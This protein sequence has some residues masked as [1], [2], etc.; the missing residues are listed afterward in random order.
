MSGTL[1]AG[2]ATSNIT[3]WLDV[4]IPGNFKPSY[5]ADVQDELLAKALVLDNGH[6]R[7]AVVTCDLIVIPQTIADEAK[8]RIQERCNIPP[9]CVMINATH[10]HSGAAI[11]DLLSTP[12]NAD[13]IAWV[14]LKIADAVERALRQLRPARIGFAS[15]TE[16]RISFYRRWRMNDGTV[17]M[18][19][20][21]NN[22]D[23]VEPMG[24]IDP[25][26]AMLY[27]EDECDNPIAVAASFSLHYVGVDHGKQVSPDYFGHF[28]R[29]MRRYLGNTCVP[30]L[31]NAASGQ[32]NNIDFSGQRIWKDRGHKQAKKMA[33]VLAGHI[34]TEIQLMDMQDTLELHSKIDTFTYNRKTITDEDLKIAGRILNGDCEYTTGPFSWVVGQPIPKERAPTYAVECQRLAKL[35]EALA[36]PVQAIRLNDAAI[37]GLPG[38]IFVETGLDI[39]AKSSASPLLLVSL[40]NSYIGY[41]CTDTMLTQEGGYETWA[42]LSS[43]GGI[44]TGPAMTSLSLDLLKKLGF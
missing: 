15:A 14:P 29:I 28:Y 21:R 43:L 37:L 26:L 23:L 30:I 38:E 27:V 35:P 34:I 36:A 9:E 10:T 20:G 16:D 44:G 11:A 12:G 40:A 32:I 19:P 7:I 5:G 17:R 31:W 41:V 24:N 22:P 1:K 4:A 33:N 8:T 3:P 42:A 2:A 18:N 6:T 13:Y 25:E 39:K